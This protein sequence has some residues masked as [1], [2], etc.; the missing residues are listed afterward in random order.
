MKKQN[1]RTL[2][3]IVCTFTYLLV[4]A[5]IFDA[6]ESQTEESTKRDLDRS[7]NEYK[8][9]YNISNDDYKELEDIVNKY[10]PYRTSPQWKFAGAFY[11]SLTVITTI[12][13]G[14]STPQTVLGKVFCMV[15]AIIGIPLCLVMFQSVGERLNY[16]ASFCIQ[17]VKK[18][19][20]FRKKEVNQ[21]ELVCVGGFLA[22]AVIT[23]G[24]SMFSHYE[25]WT[26][27]DSIYYCVIT[28]TTIGF[29]DFVAL[30]VNESNS[31]S[32]CFSFYV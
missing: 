21:T 12:G 31:I 6:L 1:V 2:S 17:L 5:A 3:F 13:Y 27:F 29:G 32:L 7:E 23:G 24:A 8:T 16:F 19:F 26:Y 4:G 15:Y 20:R 25:G 22:I 11:F 18:C 30:Q 14:H 10:H 9:I 28:L